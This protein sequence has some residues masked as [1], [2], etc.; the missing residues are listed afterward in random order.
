METGTEDAINGLRS[1]YDA[2]EFNTQRWL[3]SPR[4]PEKAHVIS[5]NILILYHK[6]CN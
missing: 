2:T 4:K 1:N 5:Y 3:G 6:A